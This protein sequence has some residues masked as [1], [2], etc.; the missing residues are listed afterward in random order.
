M[1]LIL[2]PWCNAAEYQLN[3]P[4]PTPPTR[5]LIEYTGFNENQHYL[6]GI[7]RAPEQTEETARNIGYLGFE[8]QDW[9]GWTHYQSGLY[10]DLFHYL[11][12]PKQG[13][14]RVKVYLYEETFDSSR[15]LIKEQEESTRYGFGVSIAPVFQP[16]NNLFFS[17]GAGTRPVFLSFDWNQQEFPLTTELHAGFDWFITDNIDLISRWQLFQAYDRDYLTVD[18]LSAWWWGIRLQM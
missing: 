11:E 8:Y 18:N 10:I 3:N 5:L 12:N 15:E 17:L 1:L 2:I 16:R 4:E 14:L 13:G 9:N 7:S 6:F